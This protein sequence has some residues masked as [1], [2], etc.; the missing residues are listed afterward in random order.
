M[1]FLELFLLC[2][3]LRESP[4]LSDLEKT[5]ISRNA[6]DVARRG[7]TPGLL[8]RRGGK[9]MALRD[10]ARE[11]AC[12]L[13]ELAEVLDVGEAEPVYRASLNPLLEAIDDPD[14]AP[15]ARILA[16]MRE[17][18]ESFQAYALRMSG[19]HGESFRSH[20]LPSDQAAAFVRQ[21]ED[22]LTEQKRTEASDTQSFDEFLQRYFAQID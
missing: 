8:L 9:D 12:D 11:L 16:E 20:P 18:G 4:P 19:R 6:L 7:R 13:R 5:E 21:A 14:A 17:T 10:W 15:S 22:S 3:L 2:C 1:R